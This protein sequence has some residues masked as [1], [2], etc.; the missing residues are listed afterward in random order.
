MA[1]ITISIP[2]ELEEDIK[3]ISKIKVSLAVAKLIKSELDKIARIKSILSKSQLSESDVKELSEKTDR[4]LSK[5]LRESV[6]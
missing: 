3:S 6:K 1:E 5:R 2:D 4:A